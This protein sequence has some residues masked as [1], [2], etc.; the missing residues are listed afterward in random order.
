MGGSRSTDYYRYSCVTRKR[1]LLLLLLDS[2]VFSFK[3]T[4]LPVCWLDYSRIWLDF[5]VTTQTSDIVATAF[6]IIKKMFFFLSARNYLEYLWQVI[7]FLQRF[8]WFFFFLCTQLGQRRHSERTTSR[9]VK[10]HMD[11]LWS[12]PTHQTRDVI[13]YACLQQY[14]LCHVMPM[15]T[16]CSENF[17]I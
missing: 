3:D 11:V 14:A 13:L 10:N 4:C 6:S 5:K 1:S 15:G 12:T 8:R 17:K 9:C 16:I 2:F 7:F